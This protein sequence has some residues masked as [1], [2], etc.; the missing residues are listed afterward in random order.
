MRD[1][2]VVGVD[3]GDAESPEVEVAYLRRKTE[4]KAA[5]NR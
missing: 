3:V 1:V 5:H 4:M 2:D